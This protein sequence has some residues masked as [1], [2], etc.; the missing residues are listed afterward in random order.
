MD[1][2]EMILKGTTRLSPLSPVTVVADDH[3]AIMSTPGA[4]KSGYNN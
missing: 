4:V 3:A 2:P 1:V